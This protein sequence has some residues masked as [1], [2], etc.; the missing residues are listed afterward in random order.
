MATLFAC[1]FYNLTAVLIPFDQTDDAVISMLRRSAADTVVTLPGS[2]PFDSVVKGY[3]ALRQLVWVVDEGSRHLDWNEVPKGMGGKVNVSTWQDVVQDS[4]ADAG[5]ELPPVADQKEARDITVF[6]QTNPGVMEEMVRFTSANLVSAVSAQL[7]AVPQSQR[8]GPSDLFLPADSLTA[9]HTLVLALTALYSNASV[10]FNSAA[11][12]DMDLALATVGVAPTVIVA[13]PKSLLTLHEETSGTLK[14]FIASKIHWM[15]TQTLTQNG[16]MPAASLLTSYNDS[17]RPALGRT[18]GKLRLV[19]TADKAGA[20]TPP[21][22]SAVL[23]DLR[24]YTGARVIYSLTAPKVAGA[25]AQTGFYDY[26]VHED[27]CSHFGPPLT[28]VEVVLRDSGNHKTTD[29]KAEG[30]VRPHPLILVPCR[31]HTD[32]LSTDCRSWPLRRRW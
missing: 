18:P 22:S 28:S 29:D 14:S 31:V 11:G 25:V 13:T 15:Q 10:A 9:T 27:K 16:V 21:L 26:R 2:F 12:K 6:W 24:I 20:G 32:T 30:E 7:F 3:P 4:P 23:S 17:M 5:K 1:A 19:Y 8:I